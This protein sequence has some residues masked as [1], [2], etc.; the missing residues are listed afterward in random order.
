M[1]KAC[2]SG[3]I[4]RHKLDLSMQSWFAHL[5][6]AHTWHLRQKIRHCPPLSIISAPN[7]V[8][9]FVLILWAMPTLRF[10]FLSIWWAMPTLLLDLREIWNLMLFA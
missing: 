8:G 10:S 5:A 6:H 4:E 2:E 1:K 7:L 9:F 3:K